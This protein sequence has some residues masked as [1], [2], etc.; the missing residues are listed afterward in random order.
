M[1]KGKLEFR[2]VMIKVAVNRK[3][4]GVHNTISIFKMAP[5]GFMVFGIMIA[6]VNYFTKGRAIKKKSFGCEG[7]PGAAACGGNCENKKEGEE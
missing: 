4:I 3:K 7:C 6:L 1:G 5:G 2:Y